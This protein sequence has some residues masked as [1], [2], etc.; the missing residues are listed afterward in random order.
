MFTRS[1]YSFW[2]LFWNRPIKLS[3]N[4]SFYNA[5]QLGEISTWPNWISDWKSWRY[6]R[7]FKH[8]KLSK[9]LYRYTLNIW[10]MVV[11]PTV[12]TLLFQHIPAMATN[13]GRLNSESV[14]WPLPDQ[15]QM[16]MPRA[17]LSTPC[18]S[19]FWIFSNADSGH[20][21]RLQIEEHDS[22]QRFKV[23][24]KHQIFAQQYSCV[25]EN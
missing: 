25:L 20:P 21:A 22:C 6:K 11:L 23:T 2:V 3:P 19:A 16:T 13:G 9:R 4:E 7:N 14:T 18:F 8:F 15:S 1:Y 17:W 10:E 12:S 5:M 24:W